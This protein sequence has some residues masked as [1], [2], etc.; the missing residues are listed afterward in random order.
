MSIFAYPLPFLSFSAHFHAPP[1]SFAHVRRRF[2]SSFTLLPLV[3]PSPRIY[4]VPSS[5]PTPAQVVKR[6]SLTCAFIT[7]F[8]CNILIITSRNFIV[9]RKCVTI[10]RRESL[11][12][13]GLTVTVDRKTTLEITT[14][15]L[16]WHVMQR[17]QILRSPSRERD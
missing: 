13:A 5:F 10:A 16:P 1:P 14:A 11:E 6:C 17:A 4:S 8:P 3:S 7:P 2:W 15:R 9:N 12:T